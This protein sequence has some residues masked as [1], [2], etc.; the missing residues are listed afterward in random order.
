MFL[1]TEGPTSAPS[2]EIAG[3]WSLSPESFNDF[4]DPLPVI[5]KIYKILNGFRAP[6][7]LL[8]KWSIAD[9]Q[10]SCQEFFNR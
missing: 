1:T 3:S 10:T 6:S 5:C 4:V 2:A 7:S 8:M 9:I